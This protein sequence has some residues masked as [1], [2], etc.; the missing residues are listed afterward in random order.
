MIDNLESILVFYILGV[1]ISTTLVISWFFTSLP[2][3][4]TK[5]I[6]F[7]KIETAC[8]NWAEWLGWVKSKSTLLAELLGCPICFSFWVSLSVASIIA[9]LNGLAYDPASSGANCA[10]RI[11]LIGS[12]DVEVWDTRA[13]H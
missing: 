13:P 1:L 6:A 7:G 2:L 3:H 12:V 4:L 5:I 9:M 10:A 11:P 8:N